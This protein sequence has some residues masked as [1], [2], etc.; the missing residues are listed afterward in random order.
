LLKP[1]AEDTQAHLAKVSH[2]LE[3]REIPTLRDVYPQLAHE[4]AGYPFQPYQIH[5][6]PSAT[7]TC[8]IMHSSGS[9][10]L[11]KHIPQTHIGTTQ[12][13]VLSKEWKEHSPR[14]LIGSM[15][16]PAFNPFS[17]GLQLFHPIFTLV[18]IAVFPPVSASGGSLGIP[19][20]QSVIDHAKS[21]GANAL[22]AVPFFI[23]AWSKSPEIVEYLKTLEFVLASAGVRLQSLY[24]GT[25]FG[26]T[27]S[28]IPSEDRMDWEYAK[29]LEEVD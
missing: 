13:V 25:E 15:A 18:P 4:D 14:L 8:V 3:I 21:T 20:P 9:T 26:L 7:E 16:L 5:R 2:E 11:P 27:V 19:T 29:F 23:E 12:L 28:L 6:R 24:G 17:I 1:L 10:G 22:V